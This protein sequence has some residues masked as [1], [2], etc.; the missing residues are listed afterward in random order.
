MTAPGPSPSQV[1][2][3]CTALCTDA[4]ARPHGCRCSG[5]DF[6]MGNTLSKPSTH[7][8][9]LA[10]PPSSTQP[11]PLSMHPAHKNRQLDERHLASL[12]SFASNLERRFHTKPVPPNLP[13]ELQA[14]VDK[15][16]LPASPLLASK[17][18]LLDRHGSELWNSST[19]LVRDESASKNE[20]RRRLL[21]LIRV[22]AV[23]LLDA[24]QTG[25]RSGN[26]LDS[27]IRVLRVSLKA[28]KFCYEQG[29]FDACLKALERAA[30]WQQ[31]I[32]NRGR[33]LDPDVLEIHEKLSAEY[34]ILRTALAWKQSKLDVA[35][36]F[37]SKSGLDPSRLCPETAEMLT[38]ILFEIGKDQ[39]RRKECEK[40][41]KW[42]DRAYNVIGEQSLEAL[43]NDA[44]E[45]R[46]AVLNYLIQ[47]HLKL[48]SPHAKEKAS[49]LIDMLEMNNGDPMVVS[50]LRL[51]LLTSEETPDAEHYHDALDRM[52][53]QVVLTDPNFRTIIHHIHRLTKWKPELALKA[54]DGLLYS[55]LFE[56]ENKS[57]IE[58]A[59]MTRI[60]VTVESNQ[61]DT[62]ALSE[63]LDH[64]NQYMGEPL[65][66]PATHASQTILWKRIEGYCKQGHHQEAEELSRLALHPVF[67][68]SGEQNQAKIARKS[69]LC[70]I[71]RRDWTTAR[72]TFFQMS[73]SGRKEPLT[74]LLMYKVALQEHDQPFAAECLDVVCS[75]SGADATI[76]YACVMDAQGA[77]DKQSTILA[78]QKVLEKY[79]YSPPSGVHLPALLRCTARML[80]NEIEVPNSPHDDLMDQLENLFHGAASQADKQKQGEG[81]KRCPVFPKEE[82]EWFSRN[83]YNICRLI[84]FLDSCIKFTSLL[85]NTESSE[86]AS[87]MPADIT[88]RLLIA[89]FIAGSSSVVL[90]RSSDSIP[91][92]INAYASV[93][94]H[95]KAYRTLL[96]SHMRVSDLGDA[97]RADLFSKRAQLLRHELEAALKTH[98]WDNLDALFAECLDHDSAHKTR[99]GEQ[100]WYAHHL[101]TLAD[102]ALNVHAELCK[103]DSKPSDE[104]SA[105]P[106][107]ST[108][109]HRRRILDVL[110]RIIN[111]SWQLNRS[112]ASS[113]VHKEMAHLSRWLRCL[114]QLALATP[115]LLPSNTNGIAASSSSSSSSSPD[116][117]A[118]SCVHQAT[119]I[120]ST[121][122]PSS[123][124]SLYPQ[125]ELEWLATTA[126]NHA[127]D[128]YCAEND[129]KCKVWGEAAVGLAGAGRKSDGG[130]LEGVLRRKLADLAL[131]S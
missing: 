69:I 19:R 30:Y 52:M 112:D 104:A 108:V 18:D 11:F 37:Y 4:V 127:V 23:L 27:S 50:L 13:Q 53:K 29:H 3:H 64:A 20:S 90:A 109:Q 77:E 100:T 58:K 51:D 101:A 75:Q 6:F 40:A 124:S 1:G 55:R 2:I 103:H 107:P 78:L 56:Q 87:S 63:L 17:A 41:V 98:N 28:A 71:A 12:L 125:D 73:E 86:A 57:W 8:E 32:A 119:S 9:L 120:A 44:G 95:S 59:I 26:S 94:H 106:L 67:A 31:E 130:R 91:D 85:Q 105:P 76:L 14:H 96:A 65:T 68:K 111:A 117:I 128:F 66:A 48:K 114:F 92:S 38:D 54:L 24:A 49:G 115:S 126:Y 84:S 72:E 81:G 5:P 42:L 36:Y 61:P 60:W 131:E 46:L 123:S 80:V 22:F 89:H 129:A 118:L 83:I 110:Q 102:L 113:T 74:R 93:T 47:A 70:A 45:L 21:C 25:G 15:F 43:T 39:L 97:S 34:F 33:N 35:E 82:L 116:D 16:P 99:G 62:K 88:L 10:S 121:H 7:H 122:S 79:D